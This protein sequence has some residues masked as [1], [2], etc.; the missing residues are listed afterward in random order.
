M[1]TV[2]STVEGEQEEPQNALTKK[3][4]EAEWA[5]L[6]GFRS[7]LPS[8]IAEGYRDDPDRTDADTKPVKLWGVDIDPSNPIDARVSVVL[9]KFLRARNLS[10][11]E[12]KDMLVSTLRWR[13]SFKVEE[14]LQEEFPEDIFGQLGYIYGH[15]KEGRPVVYN[16]YGA[17]K[18]LDAV[19]GDVNRFLR[20]RVAFMEKSIALLDFE[21]IDQMVQIHDY[22]GV[23]FSSRTPNSKNAASEASSIFQG[24]YPEL[25]SRKFFINVPS[26]LSWVFWI[27]KPLISSATLAKMSVVGSGKRAIGQAL[28]PVIDADQLPKRYGGEADAF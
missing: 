27:F 10:I 14:A 7:I 17:N 22:D 11:P 28:L 12:A 15:D 8:V 16:L 1:S 6:K 2:D 18:D 23:G 21:T 13:E 24:H 3:F 4:T 20:W 26:F 25:L 5:A 9:M 19:F